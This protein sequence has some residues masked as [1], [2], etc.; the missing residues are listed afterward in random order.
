MC[1]HVEFP[2]RS[3]AL[4]WDIS[5][6]HHRLLARGKLYTNLEIYMKR[7]Y[8]SMV[9]NNA[10][11]VTDGSPVLPPTPHATGDGLIGKAL[12]VTSSRLFL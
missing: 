5:G 3:C 4:V 12:Y 10:W 1:S 8:L 6:R 11:L 9:L 7:A 2:L